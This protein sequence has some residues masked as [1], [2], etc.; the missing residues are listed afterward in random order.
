MKKKNRAPRPAM[1]L[2]LRKHGLKRLIFLFLLLL[3][4]PPAWAHGCCPI[5]SIQRVEA[6][7][8]AVTA[9][10]TSS[11]RA[12]TQ[13][14]A[15]GT[16]SQNKAIK[17]QTR[18]FEEIM[19]AHA[20]ALGA[21][22]AQRLY[23]TGGEITLNG[24]KVRVTAQS[25]SLCTQLRAARA[26]AE[27]AQKRVNTN[28]L[29]TE[30][31]RSHNEDYET[32]IQARD[33]LSELKREDF[34]TAWLD[35]SVLTEKEVQNGIKSIQ[36]LTNPEPL[37]RLKQGY[38]Q[39]EEGKRYL[40]RRALINQQNALTQ[41]VLNRQLL[42]RAPLID[43]AGKKT[44]ILAKMQERV[45]ETIEDTGE[46]PWIEVL[47]QKGVAP[48]LREL[49]ITAAHLYKTQFENLQ[50]SE[51]VASLV[52]VLVSAEARRNQR[53]IAEEYGHFIDESDDD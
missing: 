42:L 53:A 1:L 24:K 15:A 5:P 43:E 18:T 11:G 19:K 4:T 41:R 46:N 27:S 34:D 36:N 40:A 45:L 2:L 16:A 51:N 47:E 50:A 25:P 3:P 21:M 48:L 33:R 29:I 28:A 44:S 35:K 37:P 52:A 8:H 31:F 17:D 6:A 7:V 20:A 13:Q 32:T 30:S 39:D 38:K 23:G 26:L 49:N 10:I 12:I 22:E 14:L 9:A